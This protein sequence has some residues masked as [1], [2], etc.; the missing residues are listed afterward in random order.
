MIFCFAWKNAK[1]STFT[2]S[3][4]EALLQDNKE[5]VRFAQPV[6][7]GSPDPY[8]EELWLKSHFAL[9]VWFWWLSCT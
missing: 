1:K 8:K 2:A 7:A 3:D 6:D 5:K 4:I 9:W